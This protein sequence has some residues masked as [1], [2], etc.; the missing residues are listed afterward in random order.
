M[1]FAPSQDTTREILCRNAVHNERACIDLTSVTHCAITDHGTSL[2][3]FT[4]GFELATVNAN[5]KSRFRVML[6]KMK[7]NKKT[8]NGPLLEPACEFTLQL[9]IA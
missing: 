4:V 6:L 7:T 5:I 8:I 2:V 1:R 3:F 9:L